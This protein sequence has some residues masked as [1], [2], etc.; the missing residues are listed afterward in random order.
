[1]VGSLLS[2]LDGEVRRQPGSPA[3]NLSSLIRLFRTTVTFSLFDNQYY[4]NLLARKGLF[5]SDSVLI[6]DTQTK[7]KVELFSQR[8]DEFFTSWR[9][10]FVKLA[11]IGVKTGD[12]WEIR[13]SC[14]NVN[15]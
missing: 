11:S 12:E 3:P 5:E 6:N 9:E 4:R 13:Q 1:M 14:A 8:L 2:P 10:S 7:G 15:I